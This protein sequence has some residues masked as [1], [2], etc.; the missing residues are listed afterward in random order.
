[1]TIKIVGDEEVRRAPLISLSAGAEETHSEQFNGSMSAKLHL[2]LGA[3]S[4]GFDI[5][6][7]AVSTGN[8]DTYRRQLAE[9]DKIEQMNVQ[10]DV[11]SSIMQTDPSMITPEIV[12]TVQGLS[13]V[14]LRD[15]DLPSIIER[16]YSKLYTN[17]AS[18]ALDND[19]LDDAMRDDPEG[20]MELL[21]R[22][23]TVAFKQTYA[24]KAL[25]ATTQEAEGRSVFSKSWDFAERIIPFVEWYQKHDAVSADFVSSV[26]PGSN[27]QEQYAY[28]WGL[29]SSDEFQATFDAAL[30]DLKSRNLD[31]A[32]SWLEGFFSYGDSDAA[33]D[34]TFAVADVV[35]VLPVGKLATAL[36]G[37]S[38]G[39]KLNPMK[40]EQIATKLGKYSDAATGQAINDLKTDSFLGDIKNAKEL[41]NSVPS[42]SSPDKLLFGSNNIP[43]AAY[44]RLKESVMERADLAQRFLLEPNLVDRATPEELIQYKDVLLRDYERLHPNIQKNVIDVE[45]NQTADIGNVYSAK[46]LL[47]RRDGTLFESEKQAENYFKRYIGGTND[48]TVE[49]IGEGFRIA[50]NKT[51]DETKFLTDLKL[52][53]TQ[54]TP[55][56][57]ANTFG[58]W[59]RSP[60]YL[61][62]E[63]NV[64]ARSTAVTSRELMNDLFSELAAPFSRLGK[65]EMAELEDLMIV[66]RDKQA[67]YEN[68][69]QF[70]QAFWDRFKKPPTVDQADTY[71]A[72]VQIND[73]DLVTRDLDW[74]KQKARLGLEN[75][76]LKGPDGDVAFEGKVVNS[77]PYGSKDYFAVTVHDGINFKKPLSSR[78]ISEK[79]RAKFADLVQQGYKI[80]QVADQ[81]LKVGESYAGFVLTKGG[82]FDRVG[83]KNVDRKAGGHKIHKYPFYIKQGMISGDDTGRLYRG[84]RSLFNAK[85]EKE[86]KEILEVLETARQKFLRQDADAWKFLRDNVPSINTKQWAASIADGTIDLKV[87]F[88]VTKRGV[89][90]I[91][92]G[93][94]NNLSNITDLSKNEHNLSSQVTGRYAGERSES[95]LNIIQ[96]EGDTLFEI[97]PA[98]YLSP[99]DTLRTSSANMISTRNMNDYTL[100]TR[101]NYFREYGDIL[102]GTREEQLSSGISLLQQPRFK[103]GADPVRQAAAMNVSRS[104]NNL[105]NYGTALDRQIE[106][107]KNNLLESVVPKFGPRGQQW[108]EDKMLGTVKDPGTYFRSFAFNMK[109][110]MFNVQQYFVQANS[111]VNVAA[112]AGTNGLRGAAMYPIFR[113]ALLS[114]S[115]EV[116]A[117]AGKV[118]ESVGLMKA[119]EFA[120]SMALLKKSGWDNIGG[121][122][123]YLDDVMSPEL[124]PGA[125][126]KT[127]K[128]FLKWGRTPFQEGERMVRLSAWGAAYLERKAIARGRKLDRRDEAAILLRAKNLTGN[129]TRESNAAW[130]KGYA[131]VMTQFFGYQARI[132]EQFLGKKLT[133]AEKLRLFTGYSAVYGVPVAMGSVAGVVPVRDIVQDTLL[134]MGV[135]VDDTAVEPFIDGFASSMLEF[136]TDREYSIADR[137]GPGGLPTFYD[138]Y[139]GDKDVA[140][141]FLGASGSIAIQTVS[142]AIPAL[143]GM[144]SE[145]TDFKGGY[146]NLTKEDF[147]QPL[148]NIST[149][150]NALKL[151]QVWNLGVWASKNEVNMMEM[152]LPDGVVAAITGLQ[153]AKIEDAFSKLRATQ[154]FKEH[155]KAV[156]KEVS[157]EYRRIMKVD[158]GPEREKMIRNLK[159]RMILEGLTPREQA[160][161]WKWAADSEMI[162][163][164]FFENYEKLPVRKS[165][166]KFGEQPVTEE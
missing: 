31:V 88:A 147:L 95:D 36:K 30:T 27:L 86:G 11:L 67:Y 80:V 18:A 58:G 42:I 9:R 5:V 73:L 2:T 68:Y 4:P 8:I 97:E 16:K 155:V 138:L 76:T 59:W 122:V 26:L 119:D 33:I 56:S 130:Q 65:N 44:L 17:T 52:G 66:N 79:D 136:M 93:A 85:S 81:S 70:E 71:F 15:P 61:L 112:V 55:E 146:Y 28:L 45:V 131:A 145:F 159:A 127:G 23:E 92:T 143:K 99:M 132:M 153:P 25:D 114:S 124:R 115:P 134:S 84:D 110:G 54:R 118:A 49:Q 35:G 125:V 163:D 98:P 151:Y 117:R 96:A 47:G 74:Y 133:G 161:A 142:D 149:V 83:V 123:A 57:L 13:K 166:K 144:Y 19:I 21:D 109:L 90:T 120:E 126:S 24:Q 22:A 156:Q 12:N 75:V 106:F 6:S 29:Q 60:D 40:V 53:T 108:V 102:E 160:Q 50:I 162:T 140:D 148:R 87:P 64:L 141:L 62:S 48:F 39:A 152:D 1:M 20:S 78:F 104:Y 121:D 103:A 113:S 111:M 3:E 41:E 43:Q 72:Y 14:E 37:V 139:R 77:L 116:L 32:K 63:Q 82:K 165:G 107:Y 164:V 69:G 100:M 94:Y 38:R 135:D 158:D 157:K 91:D 129:M 150:D 34:S 7:S 128:A 10:S 46:V 105:M 89:R 51:V 137:Y 101:D 154:D